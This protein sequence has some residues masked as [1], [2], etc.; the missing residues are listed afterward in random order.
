MTNYDM[1]DPTGFMMAGQKYVWTIILQYTLLIENWV[2]LLLFVFSV[3]VPY[4]IH[5]SKG[6]AT[7]YEDLLD[8][9]ASVSTPGPDQMRYPT[10]NDAAH[11]SNGGR[12]LQQWAI[13]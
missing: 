12:C 10:W 9:V 2:I 8:I 6:V 5:S 13:S 1:R 3:A 4:L 7:S 11:I